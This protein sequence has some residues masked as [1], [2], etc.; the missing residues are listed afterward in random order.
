M[1]PL[2]ESVS[3]KKLGA[4]TSSDANVA[5]LQFCYSAT[6]DPLTALLKQQQKQEKAP[7]S[8]RSTSN[9]RPS[10]TGFST[11][12]PDAQADNYRL[13]EDELFSYVNPQKTTLTTSVNI[14]V[15]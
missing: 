1:D 5:K 11:I 7:T 14:Q 12:R 15:T 4:H 10:E 2:S 3:A 13:R 6:T 9:Q 8:E